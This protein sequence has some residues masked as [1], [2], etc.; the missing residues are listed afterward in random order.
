[1]TIDMKNKNKRIRPTNFT[2]ILF[3]TGSNNHEIVKRIETKSQPRFTRKL[4][5]IPNKINAYLRVYYSD[6]GHNDGDYFS[7]E[8][9]MFVYKAFIEK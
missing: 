8:Y 7:K 3:K 1:M 9:L 6:K 2:L 4:K 5:L